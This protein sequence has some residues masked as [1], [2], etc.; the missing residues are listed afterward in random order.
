MRR[1]YC[2]PVAELNKEV[3]KRWKNLTD[4]QRD[5]YDEEASGYQKIPSKLVPFQ[6]L[7]AAEQGRQKFRSGY[8]MFNA[9]MRKEIADSN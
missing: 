6:P 1:K 7:T 9:H 8:M 2:L 3:T 4:E 5:I